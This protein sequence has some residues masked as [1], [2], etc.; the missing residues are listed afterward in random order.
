MNPWFMYAEKIAGSFNFRHVM[1]NDEQ[2]KL[3][4]KEWAS[5]EFNLPNWR[6]EVCWP[7]D[8]DSF[9]QHLV[10]TTAINAHY[11]EAGKN[12]KFWTEWHG[13]KWVGS[14]AMSA[15]VMRAIEEGKPILNPKYLAEMSSREMAGIFC[16]D[17]EIPL[18]GR[19]AA[20]WCHVGTN[21]MTKYGG[22]FKNLFED[23]DY[24]C[25][26]NGR[27]ICERLVRDFPQAFSDER[28]FSRNCLS[29]K[30][31]FQK[32]ALL[33]PLLYYGRS[34]DSRLLVQLK[35]PEAIS[36]VADYQL[37]KILREK[38]ILAY[39]DSLDEK[40]IMLN[41]IKEGSEAEVEI[42]LATLITVVNMLN[43]INARRAEL[44]L[45]RI[46]MPHLDFRLWRAGRESLMPHHITKTLD[47]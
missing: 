7:F 12:E 8:N 31:F 39:S 2:L 30:I 10:I 4:A 43:A 24:R 46:T 28:A 23:A 47:Y 44:A 25:F 27:G 16:R 1:I 15:C 42:R 36:P 26:N 6:L 13:K 18:L 29:N 19:R 5:G 38:D 40:I 20:I 37:P 33:A 22:H 21:L 32:K 17:S 9:I 11:Q 14:L 3:I 35:D 41:E 45:S 34:S